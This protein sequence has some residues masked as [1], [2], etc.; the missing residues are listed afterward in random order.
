M[1]EGCILGAKIRSCRSLIIGG[2]LPALQKPVHQGLQGYSGPPYFIRASA[3]PTGVKYRW[4]GS[5]PKLPYAGRL[6]QWQ[7]PVSE[8]R[9][10]GKLHRQWNL[11]G[12]NEPP[13]TS[14][15]TWRSPLRTGARSSPKDGLAAAV[16]R[17][18][19]PQHWRRWNLLHGCATC[20]GRRLCRLARLPARQWSPVA[21][22][23]KHGRNRLGPAG[24]GSARRSAPGTGAGFFTRSA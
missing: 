13:A 24:C 14:A 11:W 17:T 5:A 12:I 4:R 15:E 22:A 21:V 2:P 23:G 20:P 16:A 1:T 10:E 19:W 18:G 6:R 9:D 3:V 7:F 8:V